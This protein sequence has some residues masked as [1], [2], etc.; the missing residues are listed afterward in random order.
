MQQKTVP[1]IILSRLQDKEP[2]CPTFFHCCE[3]VMQHAIQNFISP[4][5]SNQSKASNLL[6]ALFD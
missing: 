1:K 3:Q 5:D 6:Y 4:P 2:L